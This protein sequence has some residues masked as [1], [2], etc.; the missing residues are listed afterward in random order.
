MLAFAH[1]DILRMLIARWV[2]LPVLKARRFDFAK[3]SESTL[4]YG[5]GLEEPVTRPL[6]HTHA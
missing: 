1:R 4:A 3:A 6:N 5:L 2:A